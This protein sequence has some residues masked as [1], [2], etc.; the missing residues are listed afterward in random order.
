MRN[1]QYSALL[2]RIADLLEIRGELFF[3]VRSYREAAR[4][5]DE[6]GEPLDRI[7]EEGRLGSVH[8]IG[9]ALADKLN[10]YGETGRLEYLA[11]LEAEVPPGLLDFLRISGLGPRTAKDI[12]DTLGITTLDQLEKALAAGDLARV[13][14]I[15][16]KAQENIGK[17]LQALRG[18]G[19]D[20]R[21]L[22]PEAMAVA[23][24]FVSALQDLAEVLLRAG[25]GRRGPRQGRDQVEHPHR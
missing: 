19:K 18:R 24:Q 17:G 15:G 10:E 12:Y 13:P 6:L 4:Q 20:V 3:K 25:H 21:T 7:R 5:I 14:R 22:L 16:A 1:D 2:N 9:K 8:G 23:Q 11:R